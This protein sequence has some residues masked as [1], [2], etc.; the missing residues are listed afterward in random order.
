MPLE[1]GSTSVPEFHAKLQKSSRIVALCG[2]GLSVAS[3]LPTFRMADSLWTN[4]QAD[5][6]ASPEKFET[7]PDLVWLFYSH[8]R[9]KSLQVTPNPG[10]HALAQLARV[11]PDFLCL[12]QNVDGEYSGRVRPRGWR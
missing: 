9:H 8:R 11:R 6:L 5:E 12:T 7:D 4:E 1:P 10:H 3:G 2:A